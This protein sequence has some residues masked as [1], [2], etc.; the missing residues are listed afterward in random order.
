MLDKTAGEH[1]RCVVGRR[2][3]AG[4]SRQAADEGALFVETRFA[5]E[6]AF[7]VGVLADPETGVTTKMKHLRGRSLRG[8]RL[9]ASAPFGH[10]HTQTFIAGLRCWGMTAPWIIDAPMNRAL[11]VRFES[12]RNGLRQTQ[13]TFTRRRGQN[14]RRLVEDRRRYLQSL[15]S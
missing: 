13:G 6:Q 15:Q 9:H 3:L 10:W 5:I 4:A 8:Q 1:F 7:G 2:F 11:F 14:I 12:D